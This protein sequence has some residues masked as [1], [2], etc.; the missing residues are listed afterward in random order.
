LKGREAPRETEAKWV[1]LVS[2]VLMAFQVFQALQDPVVFPVWMVAME[3]RESLADLEFP[4]QW[5]HLVNLVWMVYQV[6]K[7]S[8]Q[9]DVM[10]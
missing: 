7:E 10:V 6:R 2:P 3:H 1:C 5:V 8:L 4:A 9:K